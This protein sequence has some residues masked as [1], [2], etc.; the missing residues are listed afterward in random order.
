MIKL[1]KQILDFLGL[2]LLAIAVT[3][4]TMIAAVFITFIVAAVIHGIINFVTFIIDIIS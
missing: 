4:G 2:I 1:L 3:V